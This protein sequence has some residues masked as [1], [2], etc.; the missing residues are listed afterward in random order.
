MQAAPCCA[1][2]KQLIQQQKECGVVVFNVSYRNAH[3]FK[4][5]EDVRKRYPELAPYN[6]SAEICKD[7]DGMDYLNL[8][9][10]IEDI[11]DLG[12][13]RFLCDRCISIEIQPD[14]GVVPYMEFCD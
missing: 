5:V 1:I 11:D 13:L 7:C 3:K 14:P 10:E 9:M 2:M 8:M 12:K 6:I 4:S